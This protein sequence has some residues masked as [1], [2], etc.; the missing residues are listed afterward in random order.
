MCVLCNCCEHTRVDFLSLQ[1][2]KLEKTIGNVDV[3]AIGASAG[4]LAALTVVL[5]GLPASFCAAVLI[6]QHLA[7]HHRSLMAE[8]LGRSSAMPVKQAEQGEPVNTGTVYIAPPDRHLLVTPDRHVTL[9]QSELVHF[10][11]PSVDLLFESIASTYKERAVAVVLTGTGSDGSTGVR[12]IKKM[13]G[14]VIAQDRVTSQS[15]GMPQAAIK[16]GDV[17]LILPLDEIANNLVTLVLGERD[18]AE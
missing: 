17:D 8:I 5:S 14:T 1:F 6:V 2:L 11:R 3:V 10:L 13:G 16:T 15:F 4:G 9:S 12:A 7:P 18:N